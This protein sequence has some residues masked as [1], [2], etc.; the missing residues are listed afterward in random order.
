MPIVFRDEKIPPVVID[1][2][3]TLFYFTVTP[4]VKRQARLNMYLRG[5]L[6]AGAF[7]NDLFRKALTGWE[8]LVDPDG[9]EVPFSAQVRDRLVNGCDIFNDEDIITVF[10]LAV[11]KKTDATATETGEE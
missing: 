5:E 3:G 9:N 10:G 2:D 11:E 7:H 1:K 4:G 8:N 6:D